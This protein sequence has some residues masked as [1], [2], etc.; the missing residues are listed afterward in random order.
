MTPDDKKRRTMLRVRSAAAAAAVF[1]LTIG[2]S[3]YA[4][5]VLNATELVH[6]FI[7]FPAGKVFR[8]MTLAKP[9]GGRVFVRPLIIDVNERGI[10]KRLFNPGAEGVSTH[11]LV[12]VGSQPHRIGMRLTEARFP[13]KWKVGAG[14]PW[15][16]QSQTFAE[17]VAPGES[18]PD[19]GVDWLFEFPEDI[20]AQNIWYKGQLVIFDADTGEDLTLIPLEF[21]A[22]GTR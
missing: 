16:P 19:L 21:H 18:I 12:N 15:D 17:A 6:F 7:P 4:R 2:S 13:I 8:P 22:G 14:I 3:V 5:R 20:R 10:L 11:W 1:V 9:D